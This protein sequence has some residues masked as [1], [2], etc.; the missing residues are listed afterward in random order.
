MGRYSHSQVLRLSA[1]LC[2]TNREANVSYCTIQIQYLHRLHVV[3][4]NVNELYSQIMV[5]AL[6]SESKLNSSSLNNTLRRTQ[7]LYSWAFKP[8]NVKG[9]QNV[10][11]V[12]CL[13]IQE[14]HAMTPPYSLF[15]S[16]TFPAV[17]WFSKA[18]SAQLCCSLCA[19][20]VSR[21]WFSTLVI[22]V[23]S[24]F[25]RSSWFLQLLRLP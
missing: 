12:I 23:G 9:G 17:Y 10:E 2:S 1:S 8:D 5:C 16:A 11:E 21:T 25:I 24:S 4:A 3:Y 18:S 19:L 13:D 7:C 20:Q 6:S 22:F 15:K 14:K